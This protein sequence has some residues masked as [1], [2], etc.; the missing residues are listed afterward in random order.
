ML[1]LLMNT[2]FSRE[3][4][5]KQTIGKLYKNVNVRNAFYSIKQIIT[6]FVFFSFFNFV[7]FVEKNV[8]LASQ[9]ISHIFF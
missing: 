3:E 7:F 9:Q 6:L 5:K 2:R 1:I 8:F 4:K